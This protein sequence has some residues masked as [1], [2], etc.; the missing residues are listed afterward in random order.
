MYLYYRPG[1]LIAT[2]PVGYADGY[3]RLLSNQGQVLIRGQ[4]VPVVGRICM[5]HLMVNVSSIPGA[6]RG[7]E[8]VLYGRQGEEEIT[9]EEAAGRI[10]TI[11]YEILC[12]V[13]KRVPRLYFRDGKL[14]SLQDFAKNI[15]I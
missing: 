15:V 10:G 9:V 4:R 14:V 5:D 11:N 7:D 1:T 3:S 13:N 6:R 2:I 8:V 12:S